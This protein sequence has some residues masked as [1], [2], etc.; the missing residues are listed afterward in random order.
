MEKYSVFLQ[1]QIFSP[2]TVQALQENIIGA[3][4][5]VPATTA[6]DPFNLQSPPQVECFLSCWGVGYVVYLAWMLM[7]SVVVVLVQMVQV[8]LFKDWT[9]TFPQ[10]IQVCHNII[11]PLL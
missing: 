3:L 6:A 5:G 10:G 11:A 9:Q 7:C 8:L 4:L 2:E 1:D